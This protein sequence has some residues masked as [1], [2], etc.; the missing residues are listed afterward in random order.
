MTEGCNDEPNEKMNRGEPR[1]NDPNV[2][3]MCVCEC[4]ITRLSRAH[5]RELVIVIILLFL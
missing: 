1:Y 5:T 4:L 3:C 2:V